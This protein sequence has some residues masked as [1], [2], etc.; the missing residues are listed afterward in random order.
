MEAVESN[1]KVLRM[2][3]LDIDQVYEFLKLKV[4]DLDINNVKEHIL[5]GECFKLLDNNELKGVFMLKKFST[6]YS[7]SYLYVSEEFRITPIS[8][9]FMLYCLSK[10]DPLYDIYVVKSDEYNTYSK[11]FVETYD[12]NILKFQYNVDMSIMDKLKGM[13]QWVE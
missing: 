9:Y 13:L 5:L 12:P 1:Y 2:S 10:L 3:N 7:L 6:H 4:P 11:Y 8:F